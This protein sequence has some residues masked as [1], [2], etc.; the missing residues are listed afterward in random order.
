MARTVMPPALYSPLLCLPDTSRFSLV[1]MACT[2]ARSSSVFRTGLIKA[3]TFYSGYVD[4]FRGAWCRD[5]DSSSCPAASNRQI[6]G[7]YPYAK[8]D[9]N[10]KAWYWQQP[11]L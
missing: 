4:G 1:V 8:C 9:I 5:T 3:I 11:D 10:L 7:M 2:G 6:C